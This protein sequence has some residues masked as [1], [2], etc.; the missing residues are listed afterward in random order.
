[1]PGGSTPTIVISVPLTPTVFPTISGSA[2]KRLFQRPSP[3]ITTSVLPGHTILGRKDP[4]ER[5]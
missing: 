4:T 5:G 1:M 3:R 2:P